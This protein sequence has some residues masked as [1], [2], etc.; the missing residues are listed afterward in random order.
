[1]AKP[2]EAFRSLIVFDPLRIADDVPQLDQPA[3]G[4]RALSAR[5]RAPRRARPVDRPYCQRV[6]AALMLFCCM[7]ALTGCKSTVTEVRGKTSFG[8]EFRNRGNNTHEVRYDARQN[9]DFKWD[10]GWTTGF[11]YRRRDVDEGSGD[12]E[13]LFLFDVGYPIWKAPKKPDKTAQRIEE[14]DQQIQEMRTRLAG[15]AGGTPDDRV[16]HAGEMTVIATESH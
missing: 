6:C 2:D 13:N 11:T 15:Q 4:R 5:Q 1:M 7:A 9:I 14:L 8:P 16:A 12:N 3:R 10:N